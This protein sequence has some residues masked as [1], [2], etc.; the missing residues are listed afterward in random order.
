LGESTKSLFRFVTQWHLATDSAFKQQRLPAWQP[1]LTP[2]P[3][4]AFFFLIGLVFVP[5]GVGLLYSSNNLAQEFLFQYDNQCALGGA[6][7]VSL[8][9]PTDLTA[10]VYFYYRLTNYYQNHRRYVKSRDDAQLRGEMRSFADVSSNCNPVVS[11]DNDMNTTQGAVYFP[12]GLIAK[13]MFTDEFSFV[14]AQINMSETGIAWPSDLEHKFKAPASPFV[15]GVNGTPVVDVGP[16]ANFDITNEHFVVWMRTA[17]LPTF[18]KLY[19]VLRSD[20]KAGNYTL[21][22]QNRYNVSAFGGTKSVVLATTS[23]LGGKNPFLGIAYI[24]VGSISL[25][26]GI[27]FLIKQLVSPRKLGDTSY[28]RW[29]R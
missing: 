9:V 1:I 12:C 19:G 27:V 6:C 8:A 11:T 20:L 28:L 16:L 15:A 14:D 24:V 5:V 21:Q 29:S 13:S 10:P 7:N 4:I 17:A 25:L 18:R 22:I 3:V 26:Q 23:W 2:K